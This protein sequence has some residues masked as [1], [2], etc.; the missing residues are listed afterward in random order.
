MIVLREKFKREH[1]H[2]VE[3]LKL[4]Q[5]IINAVVTLLLTGK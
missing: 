1:V 5:D 4:D 2:L 3:H